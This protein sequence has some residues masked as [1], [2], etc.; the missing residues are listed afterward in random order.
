MFLVLAA[1]CW[2][3]ITIKKQLC[4]CIE[5]SK[6]WSSKCMIGM[7]HEISHGSN[8]INYKSFLNY[9]F[10][11]SVLSILSTPDSRNFTSPSSSRLQVSKY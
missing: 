4:V 7:N 10:S 11:F 3:F 6:Y 8:T 2:R 5:H 1:W 9:I